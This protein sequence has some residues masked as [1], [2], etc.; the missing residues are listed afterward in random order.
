LAGYTIRKQNAAG[1][2][3]YTLIASS[4]KRQEGP[5]ARKKKKLKPFRAVD[6]VKA[7][8]RERLG[9]PPAGKIVL[10]K[11]RKPERHKPTLGKLL[12]EGDSLE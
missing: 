1:D 2:H 7:L 11:T 9:P 8:A 10:N 4:G 6:A 3:A 12:D 5:V